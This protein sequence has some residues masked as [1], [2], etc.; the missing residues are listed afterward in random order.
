M[1]KN[2]KQIHGSHS[3]GNNEVPQNTE[4]EDGGTIQASKRQPNS[5]Y[6]FLN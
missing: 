5:K 1:V 3:K 6:G 2:S 4:R